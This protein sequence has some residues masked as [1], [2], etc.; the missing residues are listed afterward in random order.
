MKVNEGK[1]EYFFETQWKKRQKTAT[2]PQ[3]N[4]INESA[5][6]RAI[7]PNSSDFKQIQPQQIEY[8]FRQTRPAPCC[9]VSAQ[10]GAACVKPSQS[11]SNQ[12]NWFDDK[13]SKQERREFSFQWGG[14]HD[15]KWQNRI[16]P[17]THPISPS[18]A[19]NGPKKRPASSP[20]IPSQTTKAGLTIK[21]GTLGDM[22]VLFAGSTLLAPN[23]KI[24]L[25]PPVQLRIHRRPQISCLGGPTADWPGR[26]PSALRSP[27]RQKPIR[28]QKRSQNMGVA[29]S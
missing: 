15:P 20:V 27:G 25:P 6:M 23:G 29:D 17:A 28:R 9:G 21:T 7:R 11:Q 16:S 1:K 5:A 26:P 2:S 19:E 18:G 22:L 24:G 13:H 12:K 8:S 3:T 14:E 4:P 10:S